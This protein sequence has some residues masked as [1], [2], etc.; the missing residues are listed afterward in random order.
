[1]NKQSN[2]ALVLI[3]F[4]LYLIPLVCATSETFSLSKN[5]VKD[6]LID[7]KQGDHVTGHITSLGSVNATE[8]NWHQSLITFE[9]IDPNGMTLDIFQNYWGAEA[10]SDSGFSFTAESTGIYNF[11]VANSV[12]PNRNQTIT[13]NYDVTPKF[14]ITLPP[15]LEELFNVLSIYGP[16]ILIIFSGV[17]ATV[18]FLK[19]AHSYSEKVKS[20]EIQS[21]SS[22]EKNLDT[23]IAAIN[24]DASVSEA[25]KKRGIILRC[26]NAWL[27]NTTFYYC[28][29]SWKVSDMAEASVRK[30]GVLAIRFKDG[31]THKFRLIPLTD[32]MD[33]AAEVA[34]DT[35][36]EN[37]KLEP[38]KLENWAAA[39]NG[40]RKLVRNMNQQWA[41]TINALISQAK[42]EPSDARGGDDFR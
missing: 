31:K 24:N 4:L 16:Y 28:Q 42:A 41:T 9:I 7:L 36:S 34:V 39:I 40:V 12:F 27:S 21:P 30:Y 32:A 2:I 19:R 17:T 14:G 35:S 29:N 23:K 20:G 13:L 26:K 38:S 15:R 37:S 25:D 5:E 1:M 18:A 6:I 22:L 11:Q 8:P 10:I 3:L 33:S